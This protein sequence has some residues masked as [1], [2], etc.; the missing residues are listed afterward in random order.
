MTAKKNLTL[1]IT[2]LVTLLLSASVWSVAPTKDAIDKWKTDGV[3]EEKINN[4]KKFKARGGSSPVEHSVY[5]KDKI[6]EQL[7][8]GLQ[9]IDTIKVIVI[10]VE[11]SDWLH[12]GQSVAVEPYMFDSV[13]FTD[14]TPFVESGIDS[15]YFNPTGSM[16]DYYMENSY[17]K[18]YIE[19]D[20]F[21]WLMMPQT[22][23][24][25]ENGDDGLTHS[26]DLAVDAVLAADSAGANFLDYDQSHNGECD[27]VIIVH[28]GRG[29]EEGVYGIWSHKSILRTTQYPDGVKVTN[30]TMNPEE[31]TTDL[32]IEQTPIGVFCHEYGH[33]LGLP[34][35][36][37]I[38]YGLPGHEGSDGLGDWT[39]M[40]RGNYLGGSK[41]P[42]HFDC[43]CKAQMGFLNFTEVTENIFNAEIP[44][45]ESTPFCY[46]LKYDNTEYWLIE[47]RQ[48]TG[49]DKYLPGSGLCIYHVD[50]DAPAQN[51]DPY[52]YY[53]GLEQADGDN[54]LA[55]TEY[56]YGDAGDPFPG[57]SINREF[58][59]MSIPN[60]L[61][62]FDFST[63]IGVWNISDSDSLMYADLDV[64]FSR[65]WIEL[66]QGDTSLVL[67]DTQ[68]GDG[69][70]I[71]E[72]GETVQ[73]FCTVVNEMRYSYNV[74]ATLTTTNSDVILTTP[75]VLFNEDLFLNPKSNLIPIEFVLPDSVV[76]RIDS[77]FVTITTDS[78]AST[79]GSGEFSKTFGFEVE[80]GAPQVLIVD[81][82]RGSD[83]EEYYQD[84]F[85]AMKLPVR[86]WTKAISGSP[87]S[88]D[89]SQFSMV[90][91]HTGD[92]AANALNINDIN[93]MKG[94]LNDDGGLF[95]SSMSGIGDIN[96]LDNSFLT[97]K[98]H[99]SIDSAEFWFDFKGVNG[100]SLGNDSSVYRYRNGVGFQQEVYTLN[101]E[102]S[103]E[104]V[105]R[106]EKN[107]NLVGIS[108]SGSYKTILLSFVPEYIENNNDN[109]LPIDTLLLRAI[110]F[111]GG[112]VSD[113][114]DGQS[115]H[116]IPNSFVLNQ[117]YPN[118]FNPT[119]T[120]SY[121]LKSMDS[122]KLRTT[123][124]SLKIYNTLGQEVKTLIDKVQSPGVYDLEW[125][126]TSRNGSKV[127]SGVY[128]YRLQRGDESNTKK[129]IFLK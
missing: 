31:A 71:Y 100:T 23:A 2:I 115:F 127:A 103:G 13:L 121:T 64:E 43:W 65:P 81:D 40:A 44:A 48:K 41:S 54:G 56:N 27:G 129:M 3:L 51:T 128:F 16:T 7:A 124:T 76:P 28:P 19:G 26:Q 86:T 78:L 125:D 73:F 106:I 62:N 123:K 15:G 89:L 61:T 110:E 58:H 82:D 38:D 83:Y 49:F 117:N 22:Y 90:F 39:I 32:V 107:D 105:F 70:G 119:T 11:F 92:S 29:A 60:S 72:A 17:G 52:R 120:I 46:Q 84:A 97:D 113:V 79:P 18:F 63:Q 95:L 96:T 45:V 111:F 25:Y 93:A 80:I 35:L 66:Y 126:G 122:Q 36:Y 30:Y 112:I 118:P 102:N 55:F 57:S 99:A 20:V 34:D 6:N 74:Q 50:L 42:A 4:W 77:F 53:V 24:W 104:E 87:D 101:A 114:Y 68:G 88:T 59:E 10:L 67:D 109:Y 12:T 9:A 1:I 37:D 14:R 98:L 108:Y 75:T 5:D 47:N 85:Y 21:G 94:Y 69:D 116:P 33:F 8:L 91:W